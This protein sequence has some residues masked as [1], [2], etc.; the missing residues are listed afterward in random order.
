MKALLVE[1]QKEML[2]LLKPETKAIARETIDEEIGNETRSFYTPTKRV[3]I[4]S[5]QNN[6]S[7]GSRNSPLKIILFQVPVAEQAFEK[8]SDDN[9]NLHHGQLRPC[10]I[11]FK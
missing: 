9:Q 10:G 7:C 2:K 5:T 11:F 6:D 1:S 8:I 3:R 4:N